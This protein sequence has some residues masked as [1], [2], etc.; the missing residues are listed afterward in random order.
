MMISVNSSVY[1]IPTKRSYRFSIWWCNRWCKNMKIVFKHKLMT[2][3]VMKSIFMPFHNNANDLFFPSKFIFARWKIKRIKKNCFFVLYK[4]KTFELEIKQLVHWIEFNFAKKK[5]MISEFRSRRVDW[6]WYLGRKKKIEK[7]NGMTTEESWPNAW[8]LKG[9]THFKR[10][11]CSNPV[12]K[13]NNQM[14]FFDG[15]YCSVLEMNQLYG[16]IKRLKNIN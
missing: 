13:R 16:A 5:E 4:K 8:W 12:N 6:I 14:R 9:W 3:V 1:C 15:R 11:Q 7:Q 2:T 10:I